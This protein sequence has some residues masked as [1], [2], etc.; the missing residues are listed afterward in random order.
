M[1]FA[2]EREG[3][4]ACRYVSCAKCYADNGLLKFHVQR[5]TNEDVSERWMR[6]P[7]ENKSRF[8]TGRNGDWLMAPFQCDKCHFR[9]INRLPADPEN[10]AH[11]LQLN[12]IRRMSLDMFWARETGTVTKNTGYLAY[13]IRTCSELDMPVCL[14]K[15]EPWPVK[16]VSALGVAI[17]EL[18][19]SLQPGRNCKS[20]K[21]YDTIRKIRSASY[22]LHSV[23][24]KT[25]MI[26]Y[27][28]KNP[29]R[30]DIF[31]IR[32]VFLAKLGYH[33]QLLTQCLV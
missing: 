10:H 20:H 22:N 21:Q 4:T 1:N 19:K 31:H 15:M 11:V 16:D 12:L 26:R 5:K 3:W 2:F 8:M 32:Q 25:S 30:G 9:N 18:R 23:S 27:S 28:L 14:E 17:V 7:Q 33:Q 6:N 24:S 29:M 13:T